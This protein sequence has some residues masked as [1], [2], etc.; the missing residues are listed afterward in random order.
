MKGKKDAQSWRHQKNDRWFPDRNC[1]GGRGAE[2]KKTLDIKG[3]GGN[4][5]HEPLRRLRIPAH[6]E[7]IK[8]T[9]KTHHHRNE[10]RCGYALGGKKR[11]KRQCP[12]GRRR[13]GRYL[14]I[15]S[16]ETRAGPRNRP[17]HKRPYNGYS[18]Y[19]NDGRG[20]YNEVFTHET[21]FR[22]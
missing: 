11:Q 17:P 4:N 6:E 15:P 12:R 7:E 21:P 2:E 9:K 16:G 5:R 22:R 10:G 8:K 14:E 19:V 20:G 3:G 18:I 1:G 13:R